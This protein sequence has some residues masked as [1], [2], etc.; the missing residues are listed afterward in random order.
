MGSVRERGNQ[1]GC[2]RP[3]WERGRYTGNVLFRSMK[4]TRTI[5]YR[6]QAPSRNGFS[7]KGNGCPSRTRW[8]IEFVTRGPDL[9]PTTSVECSSENLPHPRELTRRSP[10][11]A[12]VR[13][14]GSSRLAS[15]LLSA[16][17]RVACIRAP[18]KGT[19]ARGESTSSGTVPGVAI[20]RS[21]GEGRTRRGVPCEHTNRS[22]LRRNGKSSSTRCL[23]TRT[24]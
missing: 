18:R 16:S 2:S 22:E 8:Q 17:P 23:R 10:S 19:P 3:R 7:S 9:G 15:V 12:T 4:R 5:E 21:S 20:R 1:F 13:L 6:G 24:Q 11:T 14:L